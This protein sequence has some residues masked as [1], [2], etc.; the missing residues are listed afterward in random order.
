M[1]VLWFRITR[2]KTDPGQVLG[3]FASGKIMVMLNRDEYWQCGFVIAKG[4]LKSLKA[5]GF[6]R[7]TMTSSVLRRF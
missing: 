4:S 6:R 3:R 2:N 7:F 1:D 5:R